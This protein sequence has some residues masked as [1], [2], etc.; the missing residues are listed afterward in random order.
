MLAAAGGTCGRASG[1]DAVAAFVEARVREF[2]ARRI[3]IDAATGLDGVPSGASGVVRFD[4]AA[5]ADTAAAAALELAV[6]AGAFAVAENGAVWVEASG[7]PH[8][9]IHVLPEHL[10]LVVPGDACVPTL[11]EA[12]ERIDLRAPG[13]GVFLAGPSK[14]ADI[15]QALVI[16]AHGARSLAVVWSEGVD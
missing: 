3:W 10:V 16:G 5:V 6:L 4:D 14:T 13:F 2:Q 7:W 11:H 15:E 12:Y 1:A 9:G 8:P